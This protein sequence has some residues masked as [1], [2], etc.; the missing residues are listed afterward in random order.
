VKNILKRRLSPAMVVAV[1]ALCSALGGSATAALVVTGSTVKDGSLTGKD[2]RNRSL[3]TR[4][5]S[6]NAV[7]ALRG[8]QGPAGPPGLQGLKGDPGPKGDQGTKGDTG[9]RGPSFAKLVR[10]PSGPEYVEQSK[11]LHHVVSSA[12][13]QG[14]NVITAKVAVHSVSGA[15]TDCELAGPAGV[16]DKSMGGDYAVHVLQAA[17]DFGTGGTVQ[18]RCGGEAAWRARHA[19]IS[20]VRVDDLETSTVIVP[21]P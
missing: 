5:L 18:L 11:D 3:G 12:G 17:V 21:S 13:L 20:A 6:A 4:D 14:K 16:L 7:G 1:V 9:P 15:L 8:Q 19:S 10:R 2:V